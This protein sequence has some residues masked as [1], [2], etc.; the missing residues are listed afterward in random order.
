MNLIVCLDNQ[1]GMSFNQRRQSRDR[2][3]IGEMERIV[4]SDRLYISAYSENLFADA[5][6]KPVVLDAYL[7]KCETTDWCFVER[8]DVRPYIHRVNRLCIFRW[9]R[10]YPADLKFPMDVISSEFRK[11]DS[12][13]F[14]GNSHDI[15]TLEVYER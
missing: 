15:I 7:K 11:T 4:S 10:D 1:N 6:L 13:D 2:A 14:T 9:N 5:Q 12:W 3:V 8:D